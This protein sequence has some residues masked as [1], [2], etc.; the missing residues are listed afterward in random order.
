MQQGLKAGASKMENSLSSASF[1]DVLNKYSD[2]NNQNSQFIEFKIAAYKDSPR[3]IL[4][5]DTRAFVFEVTDEICQE[6][7]GNQQAKHWLLDHARNVLLETYT[8][9]SVRV[10]HS[11]VTAVSV[12]DMALLFQVGVDALAS[13]TS[14]FASNNFYAICIII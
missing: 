11:F 5:H 2:V 13:S 14:H 9:K 12:I 4:S 1:S 3:L 6:H 7:L 8:K 10:W